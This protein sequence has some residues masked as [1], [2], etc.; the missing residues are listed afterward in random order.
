[1]GEGPPLQTRGFAP[2]LCLFPPHWLDLWRVF[3]PTEERCPSAS[4]LTEALQGPLQGL[5]SALLR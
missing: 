3:F 4:Q 5:S 1:M 2:D